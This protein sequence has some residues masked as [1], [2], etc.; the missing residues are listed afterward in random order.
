[1]VKGGFSH[2]RIHKSIKKQGKMQPGFQGKQI[3]FLCV[4]NPIFQG[5]KISRE[6]LVPGLSVTLIPGTWNSGRVD[7]TFFPLHLFPADPACV[8]PKSKIPNPS[9][10]FFQA[11]SG[12][13][14][15]EDFFSKILG[16]PFLFFF[17]CPHFIPLWNFCSGISSSFIS[18][19]VMKGFNWIEEIYRE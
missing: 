2:L 15:P 13:L 3:M 18:G 9:R 11:V 4:P 5:I 19:S 8:I 10:L 14:S 1:M 6:C 12:P 7:N 17:S 16:L